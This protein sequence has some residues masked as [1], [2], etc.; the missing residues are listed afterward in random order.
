MQMTPL[1]DWLKITENSENAKY[2][3]SDVSYELA[4]FEEFM[5]KR[6][7]LMS[8]ALKDI[9]LQ[10]L[11]LLT[12]GQ[13]ENRLFFLDERFEQGL[14]FDENETLYIGKSIA[15][16]KLNRSA[17]N[18]ITYLNPRQRDKFHI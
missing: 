2:L 3:P 5:E 17:Q 4:N 12:I 15:G 7:K 6:Q 16:L 18:P 1:V 10:H 13:T 11:P 8:K 9:L 14:P